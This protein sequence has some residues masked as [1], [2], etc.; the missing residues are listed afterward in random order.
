[1]FPPGVRDGTG[2]NKKEELSYEENSIF[3][4][5]GSYGGIR[6]YR[7][8]RGSAQTADTKADAKTEEA[9]G[10]EAVSDKAEEL[11]RQKA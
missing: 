2:R 5:G 11:P 10:S 7:L 8:R 4:T 1:M 6:T 9:K 3:G